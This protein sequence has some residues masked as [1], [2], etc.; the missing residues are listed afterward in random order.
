MDFLQEFELCFLHKMNDSSFKK[1]TLFICKEG[2]NLLSYLNESNE[3]LF[4]QLLFL[5]NG[6]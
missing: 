4:P 6:I 1:E 3:D 2:K 5:D